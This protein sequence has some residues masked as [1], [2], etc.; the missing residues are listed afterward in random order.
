MA[1]M[2]A[3]CVCSCNLVGRFQ[4][5]GEE[6]NKVRPDRQSGT[7]GFTW[8]VGQGHARCWD[9]TALAGTAGRTGLLDSGLT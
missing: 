2:N 3:L 5:Q 7:S 4:V 9:G 1:L 8:V 6:H